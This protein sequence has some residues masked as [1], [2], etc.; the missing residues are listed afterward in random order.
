MSPASTTIERLSLDAIVTLPP[1]P[2]LSIGHHV[3]AW[4]TEFLRQPDGPDAGEPWRFTEEQ[5][6]FVYRLYAVDHRGRFLWN[7]AVLRRAKG[8][9]KSPF[10]AAVALAELCGPT[11]CDGFDANGEPVARPVPLPWVQIAGV[12]EKQTN[13][14]MS[15]VLAMIGESPAV[16]EYGIDPGLT[17]VFVRGG[18][19]LEPITASA[20]TAEGARPTFVVMDE[21]HLWTRSN[22]GH[23][24]AEVIRRN[25]GKSR[26]GA[27]RSVETTNAHES[28]ED[29]VAERSFEAWQKQQSGW[30]GQTILYDSRE[31]PEGSAALLHG[32]DDADIFRVLEATYGDSTWVDLERIRDEL[33]DPDTPPAEGRRFYLNQITAAD[34]A[35]V[36]PVAV[37]NSAAEIVESPSDV[38]VG[39]ADF[40]KSDD[41]T[42]YVRCRLSDGALVTVGVWQKPPGERGKDWVVPRDEVDRVI[43]ADL[44]AH[45]VVAFFGDPSHAKLEDG[46]GYWDPILDGIHRD[47]HSQ[48]KLWAVRQG[49]RRHSV[50][51]DMSSQGRLAQFTEAAEE[52]AAALERGEIVH[53]GHP[54]LRQHLK[55]ARRSPNK[56]GVGISKEHRGSKRKIDLAVCAVG[57]RM[58]RRL[59]LNSDETTSGKRPGRVRAYQR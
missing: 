40:S 56:H 10:M 35:W 18:G 14:T 1:K 34:D 51:W 9:G 3:E 44:N 25:L 38:W 20:P 22:H 19:K 15:M 47:F 55:N 11:R 12:S 7:R 30:K 13:N 57:A 39:F 50:L 31:A 52:F 21:T 58:L 5:R 26:D 4:C 23:K 29:S 33:Y 53:D 43:R 49:D 17:R 2:E 46:T 28:G 36:D 37:D 32:G 59:V 41:S 8:W 24:L 48:F 27:A 42:G 16:D 45:K 54:A 6:S